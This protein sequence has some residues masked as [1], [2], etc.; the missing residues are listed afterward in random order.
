MYQ[1]FAKPNGKR[2]IGSSLLSPV[3]GVDFADDRGEN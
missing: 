3:A 1:L 2:A